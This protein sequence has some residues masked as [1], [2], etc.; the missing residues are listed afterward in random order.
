MLLHDSRCT[1]NSSV[2]MLVLSGFE[3]GFYLNI[4]GFKGNRIN[5]VSE[6]GQTFY[7]NIVGFKVLTSK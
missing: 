5:G 1:A 6:R 7:L 3:A 2:K 4:V